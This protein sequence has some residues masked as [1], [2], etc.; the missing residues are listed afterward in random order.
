MWDSEEDYEET[1]EDRIEEDYE[2]PEYSPEEKR[3]LEMETPP[4][5][6]A[7]DIE[8]IRDPEIK[9]RAIETAKESCERKEELKRKFASG[10]ISEGDYLSKLEVQSVKDT[11]AAT[12]AGLGSVDLTYEDLGDLG[13]DLENIFYPKNDLPKY[14]QRIRARID[15]IGPEAAQELADRMHEE[16]RLSKRAHGIIS[17]QVKEARKYKK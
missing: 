11:K 16:G 14:R 4:V 13:E 17:R 1:G 12:R 2:N 9:E 7:D 6:W 8:R 3:I 5:S 15:D 10:R